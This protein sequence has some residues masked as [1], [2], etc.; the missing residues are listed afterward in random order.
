MTVYRFDVAAVKGGISFLY[1]CGGMEAGTAASLARKLV[2]DDADDAPVEAGRPGCTDWTHPSLHRLAL[3]A[4]TAREV[5]DNA[6]PLH[7]DL[8]ALALAAQEAKAAAA[9]EAQ[10]AKAAAKGKPA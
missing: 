8:R 6:S 1:G 4:V 3:G 9:Q 7:P 10:V 2:E 5:A